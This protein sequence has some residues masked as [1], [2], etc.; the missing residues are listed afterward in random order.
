MKSPMAKAPPMKKWLTFYSNP[1]KFM[2]EM[3][4]VKNAP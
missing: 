2:V 1:L 3:G 4:T